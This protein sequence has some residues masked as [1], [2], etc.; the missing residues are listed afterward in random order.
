M[1]TTVAAERHTETVVTFFTTHAAFRADK[2]LRQAGLAA[3]L[4]PAPRKI[5]ADCAIALR[6]PA[7]DEQR[8]RTILD[9]HNVAVSGFHPS[10][11]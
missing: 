11:S 8:A 5:S 9:E 3:K 6:L 4:I 7:S 1:A 2:L 10:S